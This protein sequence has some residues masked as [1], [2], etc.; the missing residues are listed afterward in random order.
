[1]K[2]KT[3]GTPNA[4]IEVNGTTLYL[5]G[6]TDNVTIS[7]ISAQVRV[8]CVSCKFLCQ[9]GTKKDNTP[10][11][12]CARVINDMGKCYALKDEARFST[13]CH[14]W[15]PQ[16]RWFRLGKTS[17]KIDP[18]GLVK[19]KSDNPHIMGW[20]EEYG[21]TKGTPWREWLNTMYTIGAKRRPQIKTPTNKNNNT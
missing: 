16:P 1:M 8:A 15:Y 10:I 9:Q 2:K 11:Y 17:G 6:N 4:V 19:W 20:P 3:M 18:P 7:G 5:G 21:Y 12:V 14:D 13:R